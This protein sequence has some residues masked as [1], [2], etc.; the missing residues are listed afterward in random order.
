MLN[1]LTIKNAPG[2]SYFYFDKPCI[3]YWKKQCI[4]KKCA[5]GFTEI[6]LA[7]NLFFNKT[8]APNYEWTYYSSNAQNNI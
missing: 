8:D 4:F 3:Y 2:T 5:F 6:N 7:G 1:L